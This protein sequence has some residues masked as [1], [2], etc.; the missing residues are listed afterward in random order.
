[1]IVLEELALERMKAVSAEYQQIRDL[2]SWEECDGLNAGDRELDSCNSRL[3]TFIK[4]F[5]WNVK[6]TGKAKEDLCSLLAQPETMAFL[7]VWWTFHNRQERICPLSLNAKCGSLLC[8]VFVRATANLPTVTQYEPFTPP[9]SAWTPGRWEWLRTLLLSWWS[10]WR[11]W[12]N[13]LLRRDSWSWNLWKMHV[14]LSHGEWH[15]W[16]I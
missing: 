1:M 9:G 2:L 15:I 6:S 12:W 3:I 14:C 11:R 4:K 10:R 7:L 13:S 8:L 5:S 16:Q